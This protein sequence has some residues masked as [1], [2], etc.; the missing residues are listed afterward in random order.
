MASHSAMMHGNDTTRGVHHAAP[1]AYHECCVDDDRSTRVADRRMRAR[2]VASAS[3]L[4]RRSIM[5]NSPLHPPALSQ[6][7]PAP[8]APR[9]PRLPPRL[10]PSLS[11]RDSDLRKVSRLTPNHVPSSARYCLMATTHVTRC[12][13]RLIAWQP[14]WLLPTMLRLH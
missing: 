5:I 2:S 9:R 6:D 12:N 10:L 13:S 14:A 11:P 1:G 3:A 4:T 8:P 7:A